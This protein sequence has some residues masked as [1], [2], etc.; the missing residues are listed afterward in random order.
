[1][2]LAVTSL[3]MAD[4]VP[5]LSSI[6]VMA[7]KDAIQP[8]LGTEASFVVENNKF[9]FSPG[10][11]AKLYNPKSLAAF[12]ALGGLDGIEKG[13]RSDRTS[14]LSADE[15]YLEGS[16]TFEDA[17]APSTKQASSRVSASKPTARI[18]E[19]DGADAYADRKRVFSDNRLPERKSKNIFQLAWAAYNDKVLL[20]L[21][22]AAIISLALGL[23]QTFGVAH[24]PGVPKVEWIEG[25]AIIAAIAIVVAVGA[26]NDQACQQTNQIKNQALI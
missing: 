15:Q 19:D 10:Q 22:G 8:D 3:I 7:D 13:L 20:I 11:L 6:N 5:A 14:G 25:V 21:S 17:V 26:A 16:V 23:Y 24:E 9:A 1:M 4:F 12:R 2:L 18:A